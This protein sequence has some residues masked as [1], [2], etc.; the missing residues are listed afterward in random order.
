MNANL[1]AAEAPPPANPRRRR[2]LLLI[3]A[4]FIIIG[5]LWG[6]VWLLVLSKRER[7]D[8]AYVIGN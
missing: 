1:E 3:G 2:I 8:V 5:E 4:V 6:I 7:T